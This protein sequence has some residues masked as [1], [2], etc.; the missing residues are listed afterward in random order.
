M[1]AENVLVGVTEIGVVVTGRYHFRVTPD[2]PEIWRIAP[3]PL[4]IKLPVP[5]P[6]E[7]KGY[8]AIYAT[9]RPMLTIK[10]TKYYP[11]EE[12]GYYEAPS[13]PREAKLAVFSYWIEREDFSTDIELD[14]QYDQP[15]VNVSGKD[16]VYYVPFLPGFE[17]YQTRMNLN[18]NAYLVTFESHGTASVRLTQPVSHLEQQ[19]ANFIAVRPKHR[20][21]IAVER[22][23]TPTLELVPTPKD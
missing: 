17:R 14:I 15:V 12:I 22:E 23:T 21:V 11:N 5:I 2:A 16:L 1:V 6:T 4:V 10:G 18:R 9:I 3:Y 13:L 7:L 8:E 19:R 20:E